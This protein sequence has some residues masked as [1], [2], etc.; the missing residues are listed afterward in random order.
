MNNINIKLLIVSN[1]VLFVTGM[2]PAVKRVVTCGAVYAIIYCSW[3]RALLYVPD[4]LCVLRDC[5]VTAKLPTSCS[6]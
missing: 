4:L 6:A 1:I 2:H 3:H 5:S